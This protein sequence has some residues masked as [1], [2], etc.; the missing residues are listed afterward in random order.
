[1][2][3]VLVADLKSVNII[4]II[5]N[6]YIKARKLEFVV[7]ELATIV[8]VPL[9]V[10]VCIVCPPLVVI[11]HPVEEGETQSLPFVAYEI[12]TTPDQP[13]NPGLPVTVFP[14]P[15]PPPQSPLVPA[16]QPVVPFL[17]A[18]HPPFHPAQAPLFP[19]PPPPPA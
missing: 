15:P 5:I 11:V 2:S 14:Q 10:N 8:N 6:N 18:P 17:P 9:E 12:I 19:Q 4:F 13:A 1:M 7:T 3:T 16:D